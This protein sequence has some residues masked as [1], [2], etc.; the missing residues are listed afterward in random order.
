MKQIE[1]TN[2]KSIKRLDD[3]DNEFVYDIGVKSNDPFF[4]ANDILVHNSVYFSAYPILKKDIDAGKVAWDKE[5]ISKL[6]D[7]VCEE[8]NTTFPDYMV[9]F[10]NVRNEL[11]KNQIAAGREVCATSGIFL[12]KKRY[13]ILVYDNEG[14]REDIDGKDGKIKAMG[15][16]LKRS[17]TPDYM[18]DFLSELLS[19]TLTGH[20]EKDIIKRIVEFRQEFRSKLDWLKGTPKRVNNLTKYYNSEYLVDEHSGVE[21]KNRSKMPGHVRAA[22]NYNNLRELK[23][24]NHSMPITDGMKTIVCK[25]KKNQYEFTSIG[26]PIDEERLPDWFK[27]LPFDIE[28]MEDSVVSKKIE[29]LLGD[30]GWKLIDGED[31]TTFNDIFTI[32]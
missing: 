15:L 26:Y 24:D 16:D 3:F 18:Q 7:T 27:E 10:H 31:K 22:I 4:L 13:A 1:L 2:I 28:G 25:L 9:E 32:T 17:D 5:S 30:M 11:Q 14:H 6:Y 12:K 19:K 23:N 21:Y 29:N 20:Y 8:V